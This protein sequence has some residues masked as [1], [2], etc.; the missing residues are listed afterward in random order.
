MYQYVVQNITYSP[1]PVH[2]LNS[3][4]ITDGRITS[5]EQLKIITEYT[6]VVYKNTFNTICIKEYNFTSCQVWVYNLVSYARGR[7]QT[8]LVRQERWGEAIG[9]GETYLRNSYVV[10]FTSYYYNVKF[11]EDEKSRKWGTQKSNAYTERD[12]SEHLWWY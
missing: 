4:Q 2:N 11:M 6:S 5:S 7:T 1:C 10:L 8:G 9:Y 12:N 3:F